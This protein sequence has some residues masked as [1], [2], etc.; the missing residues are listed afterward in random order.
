[1]NFGGKGI[2]KA[3]WLL[4]KIS[5]LIEEYSHKVTFIVNLNVYTY[6]HLD[7][8][9]NF[10][11]HF[12]SSIQTTP[13]L[14]EEI[15]EIVLE[16]HKSGGFKFIFNGHPES[17]LS[18]KKMDKL[19]RKHHAVSKG[20]LGVSLQNWLGYIDSV[21]GKSISIS[22]PTIDDFPLIEDADWLIM[23]TQF[24]LHR[25]LTVEKL[26]R[27]YQQENRIEVNNVFT[28]LLR[29]ALI[30]E[31]SSENF[32]INLFA[33]PYVIDILKKAKLI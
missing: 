25:N 8:T 12:V 10:G 6:K 24:V 13:F 23:L 27:I 7:K 15:K 18:G 32:R 30:E 21:E 1:L 5:E 19:F 33:L 26:Y 4:K 9:I 3:I 16:R 14:S 2:L 20:I 22:E 31:F 11:H 28:G 29:S 17:N